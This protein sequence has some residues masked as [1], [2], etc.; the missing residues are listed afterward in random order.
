[1]PKNYV[2]TV[3]LSLIAVFIIAGTFFYSDYLSDRIAKNEDRQMQEWV[4]AQQM[5]AGSMEDDE[6]SLPSVIVAEQ[7]QI[8]VIETDEKDSILNFVNIDSQLV[9]RNPAYLTEQIRQYKKAGHVIL[10]YLDAEGKH[11]NKYYYG[12]S[13]LIKQIRYFPFV[14]LFIVVLF[15]AILIMALKYRHKTEQERLWTGLAKETAHQ[16]GT[17]ISALSGW[18]AMLRETNETQMVLNEMDKDIIRLELITERFSMI[19]SN[20]KKTATD[21]VALVT[22]TIDYIRKRAATQIELQ[23][24]NHSMNA[25]SVNLAAPLIEWVIENILK[26]ALDAIEEGRGAIRVDL[27]VVNDQVMIDITDNG[28]GIPTSEHESVFRPGYST[29]KRGWGLGLTLSKRIIEENHGGQLFIRSSEPG[30][31]TSFRIILKK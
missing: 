20:P 12:E 25:V 11:F 22:R 5:I 23:F 24:V 17:P 26:N 15:I 4:T 28:K 2:S 7:Q 16:L 1:M 9:I 27:T 19:G 31:G 8:P 14:Q 13:A 29:K 3:V 6:L 21:V 10:T 30:K 18:I